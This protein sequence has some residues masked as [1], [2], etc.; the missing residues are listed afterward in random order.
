MTQNCF[1]NYRI[2]NIQTFFVLP[3]FRE[4]GIGI[5][6]YSPLGRGFFSSGAMVIENQSN[7]FTERFV[8]LPHKC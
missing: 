8:D 1:L 4:L 5:V 3:I 6:T 2:I 7:D